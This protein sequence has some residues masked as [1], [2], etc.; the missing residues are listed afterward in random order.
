[1][2]TDDLK[3]KLATVLSAD[4][5]GFG[6]LMCRDEL[7]TVVTLNTYRK[8]MAELIQRHRGRVVDAVGD[9]LLAEF[10]CAVDAAT[11]AL[12]IQ[13]ELGSRNAE[14]AEDKRMRFRIGINF[15]EV[16]EE[17]GRIYGTGVN[18]AARLES[19]AEPGGI[20]ISRPVFGRIRGLLPLRFRYLGKHSVK[21]ICTQVEVYQIIQ[22]QTE[23][24]GKDFV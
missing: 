20:C 12:A 5:A 16:I 4:A 22:A 10:G 7:S 11:C 24:E 14:L 6:R 3:R 1:M 18:I 21:N 17:G 9:N 8:I 2:T 19:I 15:G 13:E 23:S